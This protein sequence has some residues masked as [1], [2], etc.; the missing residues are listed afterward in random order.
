[1]S[2]MPWEPADTVPRRML[3]LCKDTLRHALAR[4]IELERQLK[5]T[6]AENQRLKRTIHRLRKRQP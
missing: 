6:N 2:T 3:E 1:M 5:K 4:T